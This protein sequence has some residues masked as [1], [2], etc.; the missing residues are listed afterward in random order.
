MKDLLQDFEW[1]VYARYEWKDWLDKQGRPVVV[2][3]ECFKS[4]AEVKRAWKRSG[5]YRSRRRKSGPVL[6][7]V[8][9][10]GSR[11]VSWETISPMSDQPALF[12]TFAHVDYANPDAI[13]AFASTYGSLRR[14]GA[15]QHQDRVVKGRSGA[16]YA[17]G[18]S[19]LD[20]AVEIVS[21]REALSLGKDRSVDQELKFR[22]AWSTPA[23]RDAGLK[24]A[25]Q[26]ARDNGKL[27]ALINDHLSGVQPHVELGSVKRLSFAPTD[28]LSAMWMKFALALV[29]GRTYRECKSCQKLFELS[30]E[31]GFRSNRQFCSDP[32]CKTKDF[33]KRKRR[34]LKLWALKTPMRELAAQADTRI[35]TVRRWIKEAKKEKSSGG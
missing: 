8:R 35:E 19:H 26:E 31:G 23:H 25:Y 10:S 4:P 24:P 14:S 3:A 21:M 28:L 16:H 29:G 2:P 13:L 34:A 7:Q 5:E 30:P 27:A 18:E 9:D 33:R 32:Y 6:G 15:H 12:A 20:W 1:D 17:D 22:A 11:H